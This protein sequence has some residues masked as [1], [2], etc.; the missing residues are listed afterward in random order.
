M[1]VRAKS[2][3]LWIATVHGVTKARSVRRI[4]V[5]DRWSEE[6][7]RWVKNAPWHLFKDQQ[8]ADGDI[9]EEKSVEGKIRAE[10]LEEYPTVVISTRRIPPR[11]FQIRKEDAEK[12]G[13]SRGCAGCSS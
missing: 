13:Y 2:G 4:A 9:P 6:C 5:E 3:E 8:D 10:P 11:A 12:Y 1:G 7:V